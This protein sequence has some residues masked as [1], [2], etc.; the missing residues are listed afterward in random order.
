MTMSNSEAG[1]RGWRG[2]IT[3][4]LL[5]AAVIHLLPLV[6]VLGADRLASLYGLSFAEPSLL[7][8]MRHR[9]VL[10]GI[11]GVFLIYAAF[12]PA[13]QSAAF[14][15]GFSSVLSFLALAWT[16]SGYNESVGRVVTADIV[17]LG[18]LVIGSVAYRLNRR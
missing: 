11:L 3:A 13:A 10:F 18:C 16:T 17:A 6:G 7:I 1:S 12:R 14:I 9:A 8:L 4:M 5:V 15:A 2:L